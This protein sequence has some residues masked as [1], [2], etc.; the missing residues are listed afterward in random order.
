MPGWRCAPHGDTGRREPLVRTGP[1]ARGTLGLAEESASRGVPMRGPWPAYASPLRLVV[2]RQEGQAPA[3]PSRGRRAAAASQPRA[4]PPGHRAR[5]A[6]RRGPGRPASGSI[7]YGASPEPRV[8][9]VLPYPVHSVRRY[10]G[11]LHLPT[12]V[13]RPPPPQR[14]PRTPFRWHLT[15]SP[16]SKASA[17]SR[18]TSAGSMRKVS[19]PRCW[20]A[21][22]FLFLYTQPRP[23]RAPDDRGTGE[24][25]GL[26]A[27][28][29][30]RP[31]V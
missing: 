12:G 20:T 25:V 30:G 15:H 2:F 10:E 9:E 13:P 21:A 4:Q 31:V 16:W 22:Y 17:T 3:A 14:A 6:G 11:R 19:T 1:E 28:Q 5:T 7:E 23:L 26:V 24:A 29:G 8:P 27:G 18:S